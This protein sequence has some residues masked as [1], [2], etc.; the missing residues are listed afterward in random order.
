MKTIVTSFDVHI[1]KIN[2]DLWYFSFEYK[3][4]IDHQLILEGEYSGDHAWG[5]DIPA[6]RKHLKKTGAARMALEQL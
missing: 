5:D 6:F 4:F 2:I 3:I 1:D